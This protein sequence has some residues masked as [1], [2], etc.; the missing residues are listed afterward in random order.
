MKDYKLLRHLPVGNLGGETLLVCDVDGDGE[1]ELLFR[2]SP[3]IFDSPYY[4]R[5]SGFNITPENIDLFQIVCMKQDGTKLW[6]LGEPWR[7]T[8]PYASHAAVSRWT[9]LDIDGDGRTELVCI[10]RYELMVLCAPHGRTAALDA[11]A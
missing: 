4:P 7:H 8:F 2:Q 5:H 1:K 10:R 9:A 11:A 3:G 6:H